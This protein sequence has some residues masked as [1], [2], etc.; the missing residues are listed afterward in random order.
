HQTQVE[1]DTF[2]VG[3]TIVAAFQIGR[4]F[5]GGSSDTGFATSKE[6][7][8]TW[9]HWSLPGLTTNTGGKYGQASD[10]SVAFDAKH[11]VWLIS[12]L[13]ISSSAVDVLTSRST[14]GGTTWSAP[15]LTAPSS[16]DKNWIACDNTP[17][18]PH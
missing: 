15:V 6:G 12:S 11:N 10:A 13:G 9:T 5:G 4:V 18:S 8:A 1:P 16:N 7:G 2:V 17:S 14:N 3:N